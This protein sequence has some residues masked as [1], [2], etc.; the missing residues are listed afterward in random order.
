M[1]QFDSTNKSI[2]GIRSQFSLKCQE[3]LFLFLYG[4][5]E[6]CEVKQKIRFDFSHMERNY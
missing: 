5:Y 6:K 2:A 4:F 3:T 1:F